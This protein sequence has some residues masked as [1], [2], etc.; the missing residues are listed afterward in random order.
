[1]RVEQKRSQARAL[2]D[3]SNQTRR[4]LQSVNHPVRVTGHTAQTRAEAQYGETVLVLALV[5]PFSSK[6]RPYRTGGPHS[7]FAATGGR[8]AARPARR[9]QGPEDA[10]RT[11]RAD[12]RRP[13]AGYPA[14]ADSL[15]RAA[16]HRFAGSARDTWFGIPRPALN[17]FASL[18]VKPSRPLAGLLYVFAAL[19]VSA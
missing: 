8:T 10:V 17:A 4:S 6:R 14:S 2:A 15:V 9:I 19:R 1:V 3:R 5:T 11:I 7:R 18:F 13:C 16:R 12:S